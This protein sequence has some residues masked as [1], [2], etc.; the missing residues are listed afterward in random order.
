MQRSQA[1]TGRGSLPKCSSEP[2][3]DEFAV[4]LD[5]KNPAGEHRRAGIDEPWPHLERSQIFTNDPL[6]VVVAHDRLRVRREP[7]DGRIHDNKR[8]ACDL[9]AAEHDM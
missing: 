2:E 5:S 6:L 9:G 1:E 4:L 8:G 3:I 7:G